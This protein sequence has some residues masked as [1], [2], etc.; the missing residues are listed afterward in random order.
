[1]SM[2]FF[3]RLLYIVVV[4]VAFLVIAGLALAFWPAEWRIKNKGITPE[5]AAT[6]RKDYSGPHNT[7]TTSDGE[8]LFLRRWDPDSMGSSRKNIAVLLFHGF[9]AYSRPYDM[10]GTPLSKG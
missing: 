5:Q 2:K 10:A 4:L 3:R 8:T 1:M 9:T 6:L 7:F